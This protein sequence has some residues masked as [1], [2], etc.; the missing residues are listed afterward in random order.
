MTAKHARYECTMLHHA[1]A[2]VILTRLSV[3]AAVLKEDAT[4]F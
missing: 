1:P 2:G 4:T 3:G